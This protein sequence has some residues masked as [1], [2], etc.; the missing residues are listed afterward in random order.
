M[1]TENKNNGLVPDGIT[2]MAEG[3]YHEMQDYENSI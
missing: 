1:Q 3:M 2:T